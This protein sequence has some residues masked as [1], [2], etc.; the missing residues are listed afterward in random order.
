MSTG[1]A[2]LRKIAARH[3]DIPQDPLPIDIP[4]P[5]PTSSGEE[6]TQKRV[7]SVQ[8]AP[9]PWHVDT[10]K[11]GTGM[12]YGPTGELVFREHSRRVGRRTLRCPGSGRRP[13][14]HD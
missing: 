6:S 7:R 2:I 5:P 9:C 13:Q 11:R 3:P 4:D 12:V 1:D 14:D 8:W 10:S